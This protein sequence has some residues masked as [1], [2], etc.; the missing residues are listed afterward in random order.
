MKITR[1]FFSRHPAEVAR[2]LL[3]KEL[4]LKTESGI[5]KALISE[6]EA[7]AS[8]DEASHSY[9]GLTKRNEMMFSKP[10]LCYVYFIYGMYYCLNFVTEKEGTGSAV[11]IRGIRP[12]EDPDSKKF[13]GPG[14]ICKQLQ[15]DFSF[16]GIDLIKSD[17][18]WL[19][20][21]IDITDKQIITTPRIGIS[22][23]TD[24]HWRYLLS[25]QTE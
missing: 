9:K 4:H 2:D 1:G 15:I 18:I 11:L 6:T 5:F 24:K 3:G 25:L 21:G 23:A 16:N 13:I 14:R 8:D 19:R 7:Y 17:R 10:G 20:K 12:V 22:K